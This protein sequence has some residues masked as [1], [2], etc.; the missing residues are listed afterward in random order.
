MH[1]RDAFDRLIVATGGNKSS[2]GLALAESF[3]HT[4]VAPDGEL[5][6]CGARGCQVLLSL[7]D[8]VKISSAPR[9]LM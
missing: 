4:I 2:G 7:F 6:R 3:G 1:R 8:P 9:W 5:C